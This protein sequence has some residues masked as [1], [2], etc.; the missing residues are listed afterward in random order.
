MQTD[1]HWL[2]DGVTV[3]LVAYASVAV[4]YSVFDLLAARG[5][6]FTVNLLGQAV[7]RGLRDPTVLQF[8]IALDVTAAFLYNALHL[9]VSLGIGLVVMGL[10]EQAERVPRQ[11]RFVSVI[12][13][14]GF[15]VTILIVGVATEPM[16]A[17]L[18]WWSVVLANVVA[19]VAG[20]GYVIRRRPGIV[21]R[22]LS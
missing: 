13:A 7:F 6:F 4:V 11:A 10:V 3:G 18:P 15:F 16:R 9:V 17:L 1:N 12:I 21:R 14:G 5:A 2:R 20:A 22:M 8:P 19:T